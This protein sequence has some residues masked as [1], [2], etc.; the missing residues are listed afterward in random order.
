MLGGRDLYIHNFTVVYI[1]ILSE[2]T[3]E[4]VHDIQALRSRL[5]T[6]ITHVV[7]NP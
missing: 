7:Y 5:R 6:S 2:Y 1:L 4:V 3:L